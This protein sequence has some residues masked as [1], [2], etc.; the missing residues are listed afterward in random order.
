M[1]LTLEQELAQVPPDEIVE[2]LVAGQLANVIL[3]IPEIKLY[4]TP[5]NVRRTRQAFIEILKA[6]NKG[7]YLEFR[8]QGHSVNEASDAVLNYIDQVAADMK[9]NFNAF[10]QNRGF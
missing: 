3:G 4:L 7:I 2:Q 9:T 10:V 1:E 6:Q 5:M 8:K